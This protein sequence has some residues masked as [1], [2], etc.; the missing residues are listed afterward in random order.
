VNHYDPVLAQLLWHAALNHPDT[1]VRGRLFEHLVG[2]LFHTLMGYRPRFRLRALDGETDIL[3]ERRATG[4]VLHEELGNYVLAECKNR[5]SPLDAAG[6]KKFAST[7]RS[8]SCRAG[9]LASVSGL[10]GDPQQA[11]YARF[12]ARKLYHRDDIV[13]LV[14]DGTAIEEVLAGHTTFPDAL[15]RAYEAIRFDLQF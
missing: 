1:G 7:V 8:A 10:T 9:I 15:Q 14:L 11:A 12:T 4:H 6:V 5:Q 2:Y 13:L 3:L